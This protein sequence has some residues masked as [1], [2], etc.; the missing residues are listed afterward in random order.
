MESSRKFNPNLTRVRRQ[1]LRSVLNLQTKYL[2][3]LLSRLTA[4]CHVMEWPLVG[5]YKTRYEIINNMNVYILRVY[6]RNCCNCV[7]LLTAGLSDR[8]QR[9]VNIF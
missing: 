5:S 2:L 1:L 3:G 6:I 8:P 4:K 7:G 9:I